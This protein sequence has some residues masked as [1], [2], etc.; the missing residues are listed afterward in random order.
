MG[1]QSELVDLD[2]VFG[3]QIQE[4]LQVDKRYPVG[5]EPAT[6]LQMG[7]YATEALPKDALPKGPKWRILDYQQ[8]PSTLSGRETGLWVKKSLSLAVPAHDYHAQV[9]SDCPSNYNLWY[10]LMDKEVMGNVRVI[11]NAPLFAYLCRSV[12]DSCPMCSNVRFPGLVTIDGVF[13]GEPVDWRKLIRPRC[14]WCEL[15]VENSD[16]DILA[17]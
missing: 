7:F 4:D 15:A 2:D 14:G 13:S 16:Q 9:L 3:D 8:L 1:A 5:G 6:Y 10:R 17:P 11:Y 12:T